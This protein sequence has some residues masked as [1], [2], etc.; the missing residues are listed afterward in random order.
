MSIERWE[1]DSSHSGIH[2]A[3]RHLLISKVRGRFS[4][5]SGT[6][7]VPDGDWRRATVDVVIDASS[8]DTGVARRDAHLRAAD[9]LYVRRYPD[10]TFR[11]LHA[12]APQAGQLRIVGELT[13]MGR[14]GE[15]T[16]EVEDNGV[17]RDPW[18]NERAGF[19]ARTAIDRR[20][21]AVSGKLALD[22]RGLV[23]GERIDIEIDVEAVRQAA[24]PTAEIGRGVAGQDDPSWVTVDGK[25]WNR[26]AYVRT[27]SAG[28][29]VGGPGDAS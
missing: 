17:T 13:L 12:A 19:S 29:A 9:F 14:A 7:L 23:I 28:M 15:V 3:V 10:I 21:F 5:W 1:I 24:F 25:A 26:A 11:T 2:F 6:L 16:L 18:G 20:D 27:R 4:R 8:I 22:S